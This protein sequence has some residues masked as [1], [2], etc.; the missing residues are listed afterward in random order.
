M[1]SFTRKYYIGVEGGET[2][3]MHDMEVNAKQFLSML[4]D[5]EEQFEEFKDG[6]P[7]CATLIEKKVWT[8]EQD[9]YI[10]Y[11]TRYSN[12]MSCLYFTEYVCKEGYQFKR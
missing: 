12:G 3:L 8:Y 9:T 2:T 5:A 4:K 10:K 11:V 7:N 1:K 6:D